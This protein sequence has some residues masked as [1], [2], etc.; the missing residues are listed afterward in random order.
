VDERSNLRVE[1]SDLQ[2]IALDPGILEAAARH[3]HRLGGR[4]LDCLSLVLVDEHRIV[5]LNERFLGRSYPTDVIAFPAEEAEEGWCGEV[6]VCVEV[7]RQQAQERQHS[8]EREMAVLVAHGTLH[9]MDFRDDTP[10]GRAEM[11]HLQESAAAAALAE[12]ASAH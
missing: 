10:E 5:R 3:A 12:I 4:R 7:A 2:T 8:L 11:E 9:A 1:I 6:L